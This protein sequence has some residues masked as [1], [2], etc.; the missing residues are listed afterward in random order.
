MNKNELLPSEAVCVK[1][2]R[3]AENARNTGD[4]DAV[5]LS[6]TFDCQWRNRV[7]FIWGREQIRT[8]LSRKW[9]REIE[10]RVINELWAWSSRRVAIRFSCEFRDDSGTWFRVYGNE[11]WEYDDTGLVSRRFT[12]ANEHPIHEHERALRWPLGA[13]PADYPSLAELGL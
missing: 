1:R 2:V 10:H 3:A 12:G 6:N 5:V 7:D 11:N 8:F 4:L 9:R 13:R